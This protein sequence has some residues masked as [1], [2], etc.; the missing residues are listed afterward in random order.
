[1]SQKRDL[2]LLYEMGCLRFINRAWSQF[3]GSKFANL[4]E[5]HFR[6]IWLSKILAKIEKK[7]VNM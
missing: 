4:A 7:K 2:E 3:L 5:H 1:M 6:V